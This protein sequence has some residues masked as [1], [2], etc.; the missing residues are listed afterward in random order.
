[1]RGPMGT[2]GRVAAINSI[3][4][5]DM[6]E[7]M[8]ILYG[9]RAYGTETE[10]S[11]TDIRVILLPTVEQSL[12]L[13]NDVNDFSLSE[14]V[15]DKDLVY[16][17]LQKFCRLASRSSP[18]VME[19]LFVPEDCIEYIDPKMERLRENRSLFVS[20]KLYDRFKKYA[21]NEQ[22]NLSKAGGKKGAKGRKEIEDFGFSP[23]CASN[24]IRIIEEG[25]ELLKT[26]KITYPRPNAKE[27][28]R[29]KQGKVPIDEV[30]KKYQ[31]LL[32][33]MDHAY[34]ESELPDEPDKEA[35]NNLMVDILRES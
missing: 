31:S 32:K 24:M 2:R 6:K 9:S 16:L 29:I 23:K 35:I 10:N 17:S 28:V 11:D 34:A 20:K 15:D 1:M 7:G 4:A 19:W 27:L 18:A 13:D 21:E 26:G 14:K 12:H 30:K 8:R 22:K 25:T 3:Q 5:S 33:E